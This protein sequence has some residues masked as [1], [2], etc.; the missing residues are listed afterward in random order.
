MKI[1]SLLKDMYEAAVSAAHPG[2]KMATCLP[3]KPRGRTVVIGAGKGAAQLAVEFERQWD[4]PCSGLVVTRYGYGVKTETIE[5]CEAAHPIPDRAGIDAANRIMALAET[6]TADD[7]LVAL[8]SGGGSALLP[9]PLPGLSLHDEQIMTEALLSSG[10][11]ISVMNTIRKNFSAIKGGRLAQL[12]YPARVHTIVVS[13]IPGDDPS[14]VSSGPTIASASRLSDAQKALKD[15]RITLPEKLDNFLH[16][17]ATETPLPTD[18]EFSANEQHILA[19]ARKS[20]IAAA[21]FAKLAGWNPVILSDS[22][23]GESR[24]I[25][26]MH[27]DLCKEVSRFGTPF[28]KG[29]VLLSGGETTVTLRPEHGRGGPNT[30]FLLAFALRIE[31]L[32]GIEALVADTDGIDGSEQNAGAFANGTTCTRL[33]ELGLDPMTLLSNNDSYSAF[34]ALGDLFS[35]GPTGTNVNDFRAILVF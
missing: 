3:S 22:I 7:L 31:G 30:E 20:L 9:A 34:A 11:P 5:V 32:P 26:A 10:A 16:H 29:T 25:G 14:Q 2:Q 6:L 28:P 23:E 12:A 35:P 13:D 24:D 18:V 4:G 15:Y 17:E 33:R 8:I 21:D 27:A 1:R 19:S